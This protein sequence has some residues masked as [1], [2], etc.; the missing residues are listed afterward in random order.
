MTVQSYKELVVWQKSIELVIEL[1]R[2]TG[3][4]PKE[5]LYG[6]V[7]QMR[8]CA[9]SIPS[10]IAEGSTRKNTKEFIQFLCIAR[11]S[12]AELETQI[13]ITKNV[14]PHVSFALVD[15]LLLEIQKMLTSL[16]QTLESNVTNH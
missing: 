15:S 11:G 2:R 14:Y 3:E 10:N 7:S 13:I 16:I 6:L 9:I 12:G 1:Y 5:E 8:R 4:L